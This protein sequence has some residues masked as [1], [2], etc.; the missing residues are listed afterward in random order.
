MRRIRNRKLRIAWNVFKIGVLLVI[1]GSLGL[2][3]ATFYSVSKLIPTGDAIDVYEPAE[4][5]R[6][7][8]ADGSLLAQ[9]YEENREKVPITEIPKQL[10]DATVAVEDSRFYT[11]SG[12]DLKGIL[13]ALVANLRGGRIREGGST[14]TQQLARNVFLSQQKTISRK[15]KEMLLAREMER[16]LSKQQILELYL[17]QVYYGSGAYGVKAAA[18]TY[19]GKPLNKLT[20]GECAFLAGLPRRPSD[21][22][23]KERL[24]RRNVVLNRMAELGYINQ[25]QLADAKAEDLHVVEQKATRSRIRKA[26]HFVDYVIKELTRQLQEKYGPEGASMVYRAGL[27]VYTTL[28]LQMEEAAEKAINETVANARRQGKKVGQGAVVAI[29]PWTGDIKVMVGSLDYKKSQFNRTVQGDGRQPGSSFKP[30]VYT[31]AI[32]NGYGPDYV[33]DDRPV[34]YPNGG[35]PW[36]PHNYDNRWHGAVTMRRAVEQ[37]INI[38]AIKML[39]T[40]GVEKVIA[41]A[42]RMGIKSPL[43]RDLS[44]AIGTSV[45]HPLEMASAYGCFA[46][47]G[48][49]AEP[50]C[51]T[52]VVGRNDT[53]LLENAPQITQAIPTETADTMSDI[54]R[55]VVTRGT[56]RTAAVIPDA[57][58]K[59]GTTQDVRD[60]WFVGY[61]RD[62]VA[63]VWVGNDDYSPMGS[64]VFGGKV[65]APAWVKLFQ[66]ALPIIAKAKKGSRSDVQIAQ[67][68][69][70][71]KTSD[72]ENKRIRS[73]IQSSTVYRV[74]CLD[75][76][77]L[78]TSK[79]PSRKK[80]GFAR[81]TEPTVTCPIHG[82]AGEPAATPLES[83]DDQA[84]P[85]TSGSPSQGGTGESAS[86]TGDSGT[87]P[88][89]K[90]RTEEV[91]ICVQSGKRANEYCP[92]V[93]S[94]TFPVNRIPPVC[95][96]HGPA[97]G[98]NGAG[99]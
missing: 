96:I 47:G 9:I 92:E 54:L 68:S 84:S 44:L 79:C 7:Y 72:E 77:M 6:I 91:S 66:T 99:Q 14:L 35:K 63:A 86:K 94:K 31:A 15:L 74:I 52:K 3:A 41:Y 43:G 64:Q 32:D 39:D 76:G 1:A 87:P 24:N 27:Q 13:R 2:V 62:L 37:S 89:P 82:T 50:R 8:S 81:G 19:F 70:E 49:H 61:T 16:R 18:T 12:V 88:A 4:A 95:T 26:P 48:R 83:P 60:A 11:H 10:Q 29:D 20:L 23:M 30:F 40:I 67:A 25:Q 59:T 17:N 34:S 55:G 21:Q 33:L 53:V 93:V 58:G 51:I 46:T 98:S 78:A 75:S 22:D 45:V 90:A 57:H 65:C 42:H 56:G 36:R 28:N 69:D 5:T 71:K 38:P 85:G 97:G 80:E 73:D